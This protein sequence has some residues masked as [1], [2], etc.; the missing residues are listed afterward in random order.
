M[1]SRVD[2]KELTISVSP[3]D[4]PF[5]LSC[6]NYQ[7]AGVI[8]YVAMS[9][10]EPMHREPMHREPM[11]RE[12][13]HREPMHREP[14]HRAEPMH[15]GEKPKFSFDGTARNEMTKKHLFT[16]LS[17]RYDEPT[18]VINLSNLAAEPEMQ[19]VGLERIADQKLY[20]IFTVVI[21]EAMK[22]SQQRDEGV[23]GLQLSGNGITS[24]A[25]VRTFTI[26]FPQ[27]ENLDLS[28]NNIAT[29][30]DLS[31]MRQFKNLRH[32]IIANNPI[33]H[34]EPTL[35]ETLVR[36]FPQL[37]LID[38]N[39]VIRPDKAQTIPLPVVAP[40]VFHDI[41]SVGEN[42]VKAFFPTFDS[43]RRQ[44]VNGFYDKDSVFT[45]A[46]N[47]HA[48]VDQ[49][50]KGQMRRNEWADW[51]KGSR[52]LLKINHTTAQHNRTHSGK[53]ADLDPTL[54]TPQARQTSPRPL[55]RTRRPRILRSR[56]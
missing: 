18:K 28:A 3:E 44:A 47:N 1:Q 39:P 11:H 53:I 31:P 50:S 19:E 34:S 20:R 32:I 52:N 5:F 27:L 54:L 38:Q 40:G 46:V 45:M 10:G 41:D 25:L 17:R 55:S 48:L 56:T 8:V 35:M 43:N 6:N 23:T 12:Q 15:R 13:M 36:W 16:I 7:F 21:E 24:T 9:R 29:L 2:G 51:I 22:T 33:V 26:T 49:N 4:A 42:F 37:Q 30:G 14:M